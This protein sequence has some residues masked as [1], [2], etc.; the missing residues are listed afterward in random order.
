MRP[1]ALIIEPRQSEVLGALRRC[2]SVIAYHA[3]DV[4]TLRDRGVKS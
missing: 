1:Y 2:V 3:S 4:N